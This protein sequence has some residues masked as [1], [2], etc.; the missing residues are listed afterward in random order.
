MRIL[1]TPVFHF[2]ELSDEAKQKALD[3]LRDIN[4]AFDQWHEYILD[5]WKEKLTAKGFLNAEIS[6]TGFWSQG[7]GASFTADIDFSNP[8]INAYVPELFKPH[9]KDMTG[10]IYRTSRQYSH[11][12]TVGIDIDVDA[13]EATP[14]E[15][16]AYDKLETDVLAYA[17]ELMKELYKELADAYDAE[18]SDEA[19]TDTIEA[20]EYEFTAD[21]KQI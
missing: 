17:R 1:E 19:V 18:Q 21:G 2:N 8:E 14:D 15:Q 20:N 16:K 6:Y 9:A 7:D 5:A 10:S 12:N 11:P 3:N 4:T 13:N